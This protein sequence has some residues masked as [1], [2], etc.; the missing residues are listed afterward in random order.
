MKNVEGMFKM[1][2]NPL[3]LQSNFIK[4]EEVADRSWVSGISLPLIQAK[5]GAL[6]IGKVKTIIKP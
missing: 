4:L 2:V 3:R 6:C 5:K 1:N